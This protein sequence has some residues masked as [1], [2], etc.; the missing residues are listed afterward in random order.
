MNSVADKRVEHALVLSGGGGRGAYQVGVCQVLEEMSWCPDMVLGNSIGATNGAMLIAPKPDLGLSGTELLK[1]VWG[2]EMSNKVLHKVSPE[3]PWY[4]EGVIKL[5]VRIL[6]ALQ[7]PSR[8][9]EVDDSFRRLLERLSKLPGDERKKV[10][11][12]SDIQKVLGEPCLMEREG[13]RQLL[14]QK[15]D[16]HRLNECCP[17]YYGVAVTDVLTGAPRYFWNHVPPGVEGTASGITA[18]HV[19]ASSSI[20]GIYRATR[21]EGREWWDGASIA[22]SPIGPAIDSGAT[23]IIVV[24]MT[25]WHPEP[26]GEGVPLPPQ[27]NSTTVWD[28]LERFLDW[29]MLAP[30]R[31]ELKRK[32]PEQ[33]VR[34]V[35]PKKVQG[36]VQIIDYDPKDSK[37]LIRQGIED[38]KCVL[39]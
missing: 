7:K 15:V 23:D 35:A 30:L 14:E 26:E 20:A 36:V 5:V 22:N 39:Q 32:R 18:D 28:A 11:L 17:P 19:M 33:T 4:L 31:S 12:M 6:Q 21:L 10:S 29:T 2:R 9:A 38:A 37:V 13:W 1:Q 25:P 3:W 8:S 27:A 16:F 34:I 24:L